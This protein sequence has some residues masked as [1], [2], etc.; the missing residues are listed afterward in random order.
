MASLETTYM[1]LKL[2]SPLV[3]SSS[4]LTNSV[5][6]VK[7]LEKAGAGA[8]VLKS[9]FEEQILGETGH[10]IQE[11]GDAYPEAVD[12]IQTYVRSQ[13]VTKYIELIKAC[14]E[15]TNIPIIPSINCSS[16]GEWVDFAS[17][18]EEA[19]ADGIELN[20]FVMNIGQFKDS[21]EYEQAYY[22]IVREVS[23]RVNI[24]VAVKI[25]FYFSSL[26]NVVEQL[27][28]N[29]AAAVVTFNRFY[30]PDINMETLE[31]GSG[32]V[33]S[34]P[35]DLSRTLRWAAILNGKM[36]NKALAVSTGVHEW[37]GAVKALLVGAQAVQICS[38]VYKKGNEI[39]GHMNTCIEEW[40]DQQNYKTLD[41]FRGKLNYG[42]ITDPSVYE[43]AQF[44]KYFSNKK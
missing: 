30:Q 22:S 7:R 31:L 3:V 36:P 17:K 24:P 16:T 9:L 18:L 12:Y 13:S 8:V 40:M 25:G 28:A 38:V 39:I 27:Y 23:S 29:G 4:G 26:V 6:K 43:R 35:E 44:M 2:K 14:K 42:E 1:G 41:D 20:I 15:Q 32:E 5:D 19:G 37:D 34:S 10:L 21:A 33:Y 11:Q